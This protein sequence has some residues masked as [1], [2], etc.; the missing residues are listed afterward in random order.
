MHAKISLMKGYQKFQGWT[1]ILENF[2]LGV[3]TFPAENIVPNYGQISLT[4]TAPAC[5]SVAI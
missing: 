1:N 2:G 3:Q 5:A 4:L